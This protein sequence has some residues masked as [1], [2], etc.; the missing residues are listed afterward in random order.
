MRIYL[1]AFDD[2]NKKKIKDEK[3]AGWCSLSEK[4][5]VFVAFGGD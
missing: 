5:E 3:L 4:P 1:K 2:T